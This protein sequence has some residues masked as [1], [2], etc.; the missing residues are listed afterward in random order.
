MQRD[1]T[2]VRA[3]YNAN[4][5]ALNRW[6]FGFEKMQA[7]DGEALAQMPELT[8]AIE[9]SHRAFSEE[10][11]HFVRWGRKAVSGPRLGGQ[12]EQNP[13]DE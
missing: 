12:H 1:P 5:S 9:E 8:R 2:I 10:S 6:K 7:G 11:R 3:L 4:M 13:V